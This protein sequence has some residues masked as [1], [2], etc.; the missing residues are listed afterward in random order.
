MTV[1]MFNGAIV[2]ITFPI[3]WPL[4][5]ILIVPICLA[6]DEK[7]Q[8]KKINNSLRISLHTL[9]AYMRDFKSETK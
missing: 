7:P 4:E 9:I 2:S 6:H 3:Y 5:Y 1:V 8:K